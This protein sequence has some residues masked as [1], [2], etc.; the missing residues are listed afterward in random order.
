MARVPRR[1]VQRSR[2]VDPSSTRSFF[3]ARASAVVA[4]RAVEGRAIRSVGRSVAVGRPTRMRKQ[5]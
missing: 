2:V 5:S 4:R 1:R 3:G